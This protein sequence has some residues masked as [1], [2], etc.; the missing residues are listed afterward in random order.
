MSST[1]S[2]R[3]AL[4]ALAM[5]SACA[6]AA[7]EGCLVPGQW[8]LPGEPAP[9]ATD[10]TQVAASAG[11]AQYVL[12]GENHDQADHHRWQLHTLGMLLAARGKLVIGLEMLPR[13]AQPALDRWV[14]GELT[15]AELL[16]ETRWNKVWGYDADL[17]LPILHFARLHRLPLV[18]LNVDRSLTREVGANGWAAIAEEQREGVSDPAPATPAYRALLRRWFEEHPK[19]AGRADPAG[20]DRFVEAQLL[21]D[22]AFAEALFQ[23]SARQPGALV[24]GIIGSGHLRG[25]HGVS[26]QLAALGAKRIKVWLPVASATPCNQIEAGLADAVFAIE[27]RVAAATPRLGVVLDEEQNGP[28][29]REVVAGSVADRAGVQRGDR[30]LSAAGSRIASAADLISAL[31]KQPPGTWLP[32]KVERSGRELDLV[33]KFPAASE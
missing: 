19:E 1:R 2:L 6:T 33:A 32:L 4:A 23:A 18:A 12:L 26:R 9:R 17:Y 29:V 31:K 25:G 16:R 15:E 27:S 22:R 8:S 11:E 3:K 5:L 20:F 13:R 10:A 21:W 28:R 24:V 14:A 7:A 30:L